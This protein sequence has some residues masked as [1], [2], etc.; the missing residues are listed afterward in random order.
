MKSLLTKVFMI[1]IASVMIAG[2]GG[3]E[4][5]PTGMGDEFANAPEWV[6]N[7]VVDGK[8]AAVGSA[9]IGAAGL[10]FART[11]AA[12]NG[13]DELA[14][15]ISVKVNNLVKNFTQVTGVGDDQVAEK[16]SS[17]VSKQVASQVLNGSTQRGLWKSPSNELF[18]LMVLDSEAVKTA[19]KNNVQ[20]SYKNDKALWQQFQ[21]QKA[22]QELDKEVEKAFGDQ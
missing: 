19:V 22:N 3:K 10:Q 4:A 8:L 7:P 21:A 6:L 2:C 11:E 1:A 17:Q 5:T 12:A 20:T 14:R 15:T 9:K 13:R 18:L 16:V